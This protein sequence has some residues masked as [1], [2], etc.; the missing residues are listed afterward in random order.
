M[1]SATPSPVE[2]FVAV[3][4]N[5]TEAKNL[6]DSL[7]RLQKTG[8]IELVDA[9]TVTKNASGKIHTDE[10]RELT[11][12]KGAIRGAV[13][14]AV[15]GLI[16][17]PSLLVGALAGGAAGG[18]IGRLRDTGIKTE[19]LEK[20]ATDIQPGEVAVLAVVDDRWSQKL[21]A[22]LDGYDRVTRQ[23]LNARAATL[24]IADPATGV[25]AGGGFSTDDSGTSADSSATW[26]TG[27]DEEAPSS[28]S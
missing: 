12:R 2:I 18:L 17:P 15:L 4:P 25:V 8:A 3:F 14:G 11:V 24:L 10:L 9:A 23:A 26:Q 5:E 16:F 7:K 20:L 19:D 1:T 21:V 22:V 13:A 6:I 28:P 27:A